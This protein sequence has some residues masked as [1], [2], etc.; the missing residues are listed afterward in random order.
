MRAVRPAGDAATECAQLERALLR[1]Y[2]D[3]AETQVVV[4][5]AVRWHR[6][7]LEA[8]EVIRREGMFIVAER[9]TF[10]HPAVQIERD[11]QLG[12][13]AA[14]RVLRDATRRTKIGGPSRL[15]R[16]PA[17]HVLS[18]RARRYLARP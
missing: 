10:K 16:L 18:P 17:G 12:Y 14:I 3:T 9:G 8:Q 4:D 6:R 5:V 2:G 11:C 15:E 7:L 13:L 1:I